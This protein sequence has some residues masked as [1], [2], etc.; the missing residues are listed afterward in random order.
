M[1]HAQIDGTSALAIPQDLTPEQE[2]SIALQD[3]M[4]VLTLAKSVVVKTQEEYRAADE[5]C[6]AIK[7]AM[8]KAEARRDELVR[9]LN[10]VVKKINAGFKDVTSTFEAALAAYRKPMTAFQEELARQ[11]REA[12]EA[13]RKERER[14]EAE[15][16]EAARIEREKAE[17]ARREAEEAQARA[18]GAEQDPFE[19]ALAQS[20]AEEAQRRADEANEAFKQSI[21]DARTV[22]VQ[23]EFVPK[24]TG[25]ASKTFT[26][27][28]FEIT[29]PDLVPMRFRPIDQKL[30]AA[31][32]RELKDKFSAPG[33]KITSRIEVK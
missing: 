12:E 11:R 10:T 31:E 18:Q 9:P 19:A 16:R 4:E 21:R 5:A 26:V 28:D 25:A 1:T 3:A 14:L 29:D 15:A 17:A 23:P 30:I 6:A 33:V 24:V 7:A 8:K 13:A 32:V 2:Q 22:E 27:W 20:D